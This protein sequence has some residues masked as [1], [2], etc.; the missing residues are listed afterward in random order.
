MSIY[1][2]TMSN[3]DFI[4]VKDVAMRS[5]PAIGQYDYSHNVDGHIVCNVTSNKPIQLAHSIEISE[6]G[7]AWSVPEWHMDWHEKPSL[8]VG[9]E[10]TPTFNA[11]N[12]GAVNM[13]GYLLMQIVSNSTGE[14]IATQINDTETGRR[15]DIAADDTLNISD[16][17]Y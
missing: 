3:D 9:S 6:P 15:R 2:K 1:S 10:K 14:V 12:K 7:Y 16:I 11:E 17:L 8:I 5:E 13:S 4:A